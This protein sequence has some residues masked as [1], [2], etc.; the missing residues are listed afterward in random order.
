MIRLTTNIECILKGITILKINKDAKSVNNQITL[1]NHVLLDMGCQRGKRKH[2]VHG[3]SNRQVIHKHPHH[4][5]HKCVTG[6][7]S[8]C[9]AWSR[10]AS[11]RACRDGSTPPAVWRPNHPSA[12]TSQTTRRTS[13]RCPLPLFLTLRRTP[14]ELGRPPPECSDR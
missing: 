8:A 10:C 4:I 1:Y 11:I 7:A 9:G 2:P 12:D 6:T 13:A 14:H 5:L 3:V